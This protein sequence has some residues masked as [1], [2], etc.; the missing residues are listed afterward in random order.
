MDETPMEEWELRRPDGK[1]N[2]PVHGVVEGRYVHQAAMAGDGAPDWRCGQCYKEAVL[3]AFC[4]PV[5]N[6]PPP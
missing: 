4:Q 1:W 5:T 3:K 6:I 2:C